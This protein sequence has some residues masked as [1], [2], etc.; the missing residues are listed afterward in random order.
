M[1]ASWGFLMC[2]LAV[3]K[4]GGDVPIGSCQMNP[5]DDVPH[6]SLKYI[7]V[8]IYLLMVE[9]RVIASCRVL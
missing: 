1:R 5:T 3:V 7:E 8:N 6:K 2:I 9:T 4:G